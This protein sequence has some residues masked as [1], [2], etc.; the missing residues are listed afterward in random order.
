MNLDTLS[1]LQFGDKESLQLFLFE[2][3]TQHQYFRDIFFEQGIV[4]PAFPIA[5]ANTDNLDDWLQAHQVE[6]QFYAGQLGLSNP[7]NM[8]DADW[9][10]E[11]DFYEWV[12][13]HFAAHEQIIAA[14]GIN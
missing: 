2:N 1:I 12:A 7:F 9:N 3:S 5:D 11:D 8:L 6:H 10:R 13:Q 14:L 4:A